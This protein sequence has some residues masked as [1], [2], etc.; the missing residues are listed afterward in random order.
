LLLYGPPGCGK[1]HLAQWIASELGMPLLLARLDGVISS[2][3][4]STAKNIRA[5]FEYAAAAPCVLFL[6]EFDALAKLRDDAQ[7]I[8]ELKRVVNSFLQNI[9]SLPPDSVVIAAT[10]H[11]Q[12]LDPAVWRR[13]SY[14]LELARPDVALRQHLWMEFLAPEALRDHEYAALADLSEGLTGADIREACLRARRSSMVNGVPLD[15]SSVFAA[16]LRFA[17]AGGPDSGALAE[18]S[19]LP[20]NEIATTLKRRNPKL[21]SNSTIAAL[22]ATSKATAFRWSRD[23]QQ[24][25]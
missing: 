10:N 3:L 8:G 15:A 1:T 7:E 6:D 2:Y 9:D 13:F 21:Y 22:L 4:G 18:L 12:L 14:R 16:L 17:T 5:I 11:P 23:G 19:A 24:E 20:P 25:E